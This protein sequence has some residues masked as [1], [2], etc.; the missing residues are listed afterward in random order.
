MVISSGMDKI[1]PYAKFG[2]IIGVGS[3]DMTE[4]LTYTIYSTTTVEKTITNF[5]GGI[6]L[7]LTASIGTSYNINHCCPLKAEFFF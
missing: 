7:G 6:A 5:N 4:I 2:A 3:F 1:N